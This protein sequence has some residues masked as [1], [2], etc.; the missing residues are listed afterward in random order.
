MGV[1]VVDHVEPVAT[2]AFAIARGGQ[3]AVGGAADGGGQVL[4][5][6]LLEGGEFFG[7]GW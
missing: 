6:F 5:G 4:G 2:P 1:A 7:R 3:E